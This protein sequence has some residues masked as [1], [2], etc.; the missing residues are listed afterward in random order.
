MWYEKPAIILKL[1]SVFV[2]FVLQ[3]LANTHTATFKSF[4]E[5]SF[6]IAHLSDDFFKPLQV[7]AVGIFMMIV[8]KRE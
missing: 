6:G 3:L 1:F 7:V 8:N 2:L 5:R 4:D